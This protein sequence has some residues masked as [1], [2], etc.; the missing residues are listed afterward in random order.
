MR[1][2]IAGGGIGGLTLALALNRRDPGLDIDIFDSVP[3]FKPLGLGINLMPH[4]IRALD[5]LGLRDQLAAVAVEAREFAF[6]THHGQLVHRE[7][8]GLFAGYDYPHYSIHRGEL[9]TILY[10]TVCER[11]GADHVHL[12]HR[13][14]GLEQDDDQV[15]ANFADDQGRAHETFTSDVLVGCDGINSGVRKTF[16]PDEGEPLFHGINMW[17]GVTRMKPFLTGASATRIGALFLSGK[18]AVYPIRNYTDGSGDQLVNW[19]AEAVTDEQSPCDWN[20]RGNLDDFLPIFEDWTF[21]WLDC[22][23]MLRGSDFVLSYPMVDRDPVD[24]WTFGRVT[25]LGDAAHPM[26]PRGGNG[27]AQ[28]ILDA[29]ALAQALDE[30][31]DPRDALREYESVRLE[32]VNRIVLTNR[33]A[34]PDKIIEVVE[35]RTSGERFDRIEDV[36]SADEIKHIHEGYQRVAG[37]DKQSVAR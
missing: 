17:R 31:D 33:S 25:L 6:F 21:D 24:R 36:I 22:P 18:L 26:Y 32:T 9:H 7:P 28:A 29:R 8:C 1:I 4:A 16:Y 5:E 23:K 14:T 37:F 35:Q 34:P 19:V 30:G 3:E 15:R 20:A 13:F 10:R 11:I 27:G 2:A 12:N